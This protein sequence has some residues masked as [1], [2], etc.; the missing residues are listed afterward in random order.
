MLAMLQFTIVLD[1]MI[2]SPLGDILMKDMN[3]STSEFGTVVSAYAF[4]AG[5]SGFLSAG[6]ADR[7]DRK[8]LLLFFYSGFIVGTACCGFANSFPVLLASRIVTGIFGGVISSISMAIIT[9]IFHIS[10]RGR[11]MG[12]V[13]MAFAV[14][15]IL[16][17]PAGL[18]LAAKFNWHA[19]FFMIVILAMLIILLIIFRMQPIRTH[20]ALQGDQSALQHL[21]QTIGKRRYR[22][23]FL[24]TSMLS[25][26][27]FMLMPFTSPFLVNNVGIL[28][29]ELPTVFMFTGLASMVIMP[30]VGRLSDRVDKFRLFTVGSVLASV[31]IV[32]YTNLTPH[33]LWFVILIN[34]VLFLGIMSRMVPAVALNSA[35]PEA[36][37][38][39]AYMSINSS[40]QQ[41]AGGLAALFAG[42]VVQQ[43]SKH[44]PIMHFDTLGYIMVG[45]VFLCIFL[46]RR[47]DRLVHPYKKGW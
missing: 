45:I 3:I 2:I 34:V 16:G 17:I 41:F 25:L 40:L 14:S 7:F 24:A 47:V 10:Q 12:M 39:G 19:S 44:S 36:A 4:S 18:F 35:L 5:I 30:L 20:L 6:F 42:L 46:L 38:R 22:I 8:R 15:Q 31:M 32:V 26:G 27:G 33:P 23:G 13:Q 43:E 21:L 1:F 29:T 37:D 11:V 9:D 28:Q